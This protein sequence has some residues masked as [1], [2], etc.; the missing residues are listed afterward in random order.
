M[1]LPKI[2]GI[3]NVTPDSFSDGGNYFSKE[4]AVSHALNMIDHGADI[5]DIGGESTRPGADPVGEEEELKRVIPVIEELKDAKPETEISIDTTKYSVAEAAV[6]AGASIINDVSALEFEPQL[7]ELAAEYDCS[8]I[9]MHMQ[10]KPRNMQ[11]DPQYDDVVE[12][13][14]KILKNKIQK[15]RQL[16]AS[17]IIADVG[18]GF[19]KTLE[20]N[21]ELLRNLKE[22]KKLEVPMLLG[23]SRKSFIGKLTGIEDASKRDLPTVLIHS[24]LLDAEIDIIR[25]HNVRHHKLMNELYD[26]IFKQK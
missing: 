19:G 15:A 26:S 10:G 9:L 3:L 24:M 11:K 17:K 1:K 13:I 7:A 2:M 12:D 20:H 18:F 4:S 16:G 23:I 22:F 8:L 14:F 21:L 6:K 5:I 25:V